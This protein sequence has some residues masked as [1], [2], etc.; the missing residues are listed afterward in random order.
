MEYIRRKIPL[1][2]SHFKSTF[3]FFLLASS[4]LR[5]LSAKQITNLLQHFNPIYFINQNSRVT[6]KSS[7]TPIPQ[8]D[9]L[10][11]ALGGFPNRFSPPVV[12]VAGRPK[13]P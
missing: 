10:T 6:R 3:R 7:Q 5:T 2:T 4:H 1:D 8:N 9:I 13:A 12:V 11:Y